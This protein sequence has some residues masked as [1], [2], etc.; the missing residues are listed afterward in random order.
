MG[1]NCQKGCLEIH[2]DAVIEG[3]TLVEGCTLFKEGAMAEVMAVPTAK[4]INGSLES[5]NVKG[6]AVT[7][8]CTIVN[9]IDFSKCGSVII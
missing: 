9:G 7:I 1:R 6:D 4:D 8:E 3:V 2:R 5:A